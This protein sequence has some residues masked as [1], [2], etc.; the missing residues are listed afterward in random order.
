MLEDK[1]KTMVLIEPKTKEII[2]DNSGKII[3]YIN[4]KGQEVYYANK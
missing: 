4:N 1:V 3:G 2:E